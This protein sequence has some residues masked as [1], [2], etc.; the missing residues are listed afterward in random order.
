[1]FESNLHGATG[2]DSPVDA[3]Y[4]QCLRGQIDHLVHPVLRLLVGR[5]LTVVVAT[6]IDSLSV[7]KYLY[8][9]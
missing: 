3:L 8:N 4:S 5:R 9:P 2:E 7:H 1:M 6:G